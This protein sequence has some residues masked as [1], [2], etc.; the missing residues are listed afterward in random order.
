[1]KFL[2]KDSI[3]KLYLNNNLVNFDPDL[4]PIE[5]IVI[6]PSNTTIKINETV[7]LTA[8]ILPEVLSHKPVRWQS[9]NEAFVS[10]TKQG[11]V[12][13][14]QEGDCS[15]Y[16]YATDSSGIVAECSVSISGEQENIPTVSSLEGPYVATYY[17]NPKPDIND[18]IFIPVYITDWNQKEWLEDDTSLLF[19]LRLEVDGVVKVFPNLKAGD[20][21]IPIGK[22]PEGE[23][24]FTLQVIDEQ[25]LESHRFSAELWAIDKVKYEIKPS[26]IY[27]ITDAD[28]LEFKINKSD[29][30]VEEDMT[31]VRVG[32]TALLAKIANDGYRKCTLPL[33]KY[34]FSRCLKMGTGTDTT[35]VIPSGLTVDLNGSTF[36]QHPFD[37]F[38]SNFFRFDKCKDSH[39]I[40]GILEGDYVER[41]QNGWLANY[42]GEGAG[43]IQLQGGRYNSVENMNI[44]NITGYS[45]MSTFG[46][47]EICYFPAGWVAGFDLDKNDGETQIPNPKTSVSNF[48][49]L[50]KI[51][52]SKHDPHH[53]TVSRYLGYQ[54]LSGDAWLFDAYFY[55]ENKQLITRIKGHQYRKLRFPTNA[56]YM[57][58][59]MQ[60]VYADDTNLTVHNMEIPSYCLYK[61]I[62]SVDTRTCAVAFCQMNHILMEDCTFDNC[63]HSITPIAI[64]LEDGWQQMQDFY[65]RRCDILKRAG[66]GDFI[67]SAGFNH[68][69]EDCNNWRW[70]IRRPQG[71]VIKNCNTSLITFILGPHYRAAYSRISNNQIV[72]GLAINNEAGCIKQVVKNLDIIGKSIQTGAADNTIG[73][74]NSAIIRNS[75]LKDIS[76]L[77]QLTVEDSEITNL[78]PYFSK[79]FVF[80]NC[81][82]KKPPEL[83]DYMRLSL[84]NPEPNLT[85]LFKNCIVEHDI[86]IDT[87]N[88][89]S[90]FKAE[91]TTFNERVWIR[92]NLENVLGDILFENCTFKKDLTIELKPNIY[93]RFNKCVFEGQKIFKGPYE[94]NCEFND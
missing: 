66:T 46:R 69:Y 36:K 77:T 86:K 59:V 52:N 31:N 12:T 62:A 23:H 8:T 47:C 27:T 22:L 39:L 15:V 26:E 10:V 5:S 11:L 64:D 24:W 85:R 82:L 1:M 28:L 25:G 6:S 14:L 56:K 21:N 90:C 79:E 38:E 94:A 19:K 88:N 73:S 78:V 75:K 20:H 49:D 93:I 67:D 48:V 4:I 65:L 32:L 83:V 45:M 72:D 68:V 16:A 30:Q 57:R 74:R 91:E 35:I 87:H 54:G 2:I 92:P 84:N 37:G 44:N 81:V 17:F 80:N 9:G 89:F 3:T 29:S 61:G 50:T 70:I 42:N 55:D 53:V 51:L 33:G 18:D 40:N 71:V 76:C 34:R 60:G 58:V 43:C 41:Q 7:Q 13:G 63:G